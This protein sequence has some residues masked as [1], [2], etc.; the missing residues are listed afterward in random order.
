MN[1]EIFVAVVIIA[2]NEEKNI[3]KTL[4]CI[5]KQKLKPYRIIV[6]ND[7]ST[8]KTD[9]TISK[10]DS[11]EIINQSI[12]QESFLAKKELAETFN[13][14]LKKL[15]ND[16]QCQ[17]VWLSGSDVLYSENYLKDIVSRMEKDPNLVIASGTIENEFS[18]EPRGSGRIIKCD[19]WRKIGFCYPQNYGFEGYLL[20]KANSLGYKT[21][22]FQDIV[23]TTQR[24]TGFNFNPKKYYFYGLGYKALGYTPFYV[25]GKSLLFSKKSPKGAFYIL[26]GFFSRYDDLYEKELRDYVHKIQSNGKFKFNLIK[27]FF[28]ILNQ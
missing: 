3:S 8:D 6:V 5:L 24:K 23:S 22:N 18:I 4:E 7:G 15:K 21:I 13:I 10:F 26:K 25:L 9:E 14:G 2:R 1:K 11:I 19:F 17:Y 28:K 27:R 16:L 20:L 12:R